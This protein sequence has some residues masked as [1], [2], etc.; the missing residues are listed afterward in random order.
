MINL[1]EGWLPQVKNMDDFEFDWIVVH[2]VHLREELR[3]EG[4]SPYEVNSLIQIFRR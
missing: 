4:F 2:E 1:F 3:D